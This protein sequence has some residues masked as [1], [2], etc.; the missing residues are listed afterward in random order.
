MSDK[1]VCQI[2][3]AEVH[4]IQKHIT[5]HAE[6]GWTMERYKDEFPDA[7]LISDKVREMLAAKKLAE[8]GA[9]AEVTEIDTRL[10]LHE[11]FELGASPDALTPSGSP[12]PVTL[13]GKHDWE[14]MVP[15]I[16]EN[17]V[18]DINLTKIILMG[19]EEKMPV[20]LWGHSGTGKTTAPL[21]IAA[22][23][24]RPILR[25]QHT[26]NTEEAHILGH[27][28]LK[29]QETSF[30][31]GPLALAMKHGWIY[32]AD[33][34]DFAVPH[35]LSVYQPVLEGHPL[36]IK[37]AEGEWRQVRPHPNFR[38]VATGNT[39]GVGDESGL[40]QG[41]QLQNAANYERFAIVQQVK[42]MAP[43]IE[44]LILQ[45]QA[46]L[47]TRDAK[48]LVK[49]GGMV[50]EAVGRSEITMPVSPR[51]L[52]HA[53]KLGTMRGCFVQ[54]LELSY[55]NRL[56]SIDREAVRQIAQRVFG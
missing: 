34:Y 5:V 31:P 33:E 50:R 23:T 40:Y 4:A 6:E 27:P 52:I 2:C 35:V 45:S 44:E 30:K 38:F 21:Q 41:T 20:Y 56:S 10:P 3:S 25:V 11:I 53:G 55:I 29:G 18:H 16:D 12:I 32:L 42:Y 46:G 7:P 19:L 1:I 15:D 9:R 48:S 51:A 54:G 47:H 43:E 8:S 49:F 24:N 36:I 14:E 13:M 26:L 28:I 22:R 17:Y 37:E 39:N